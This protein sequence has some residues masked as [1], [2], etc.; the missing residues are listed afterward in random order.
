MVGWH[1]LGHS[2]DRHRVHRKHHSDQ[3]N[4]GWLMEGHHRQLHHT[5][6]FHMVGQRRDGHHK[7]GDQ[8]KDGWCMDHH[9]VQRTDVL[10]RDCMAGHNKGRR[11]VGEDDG[12]LVP[13]VAS[14]RWT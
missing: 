9:S 2:S 8:Y 6:D 3:C 11:R 10:G 1:M 14:L 5:D 7:E 12:T 4:A 13:P